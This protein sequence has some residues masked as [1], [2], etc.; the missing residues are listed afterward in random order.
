[1]K[2]FHFIKNAW[3]EE[4]P[5]IHYSQLLVGMLNGTDIPI[6]GCGGPQGCET[7]RLPHK[8]EVKTFSSACQLE[9]CSLN[10]ESGPKSIPQGFK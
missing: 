2:Y 1:M 4:E 8:I 10:I 6:R 7:S 3:E 9:K 5:V